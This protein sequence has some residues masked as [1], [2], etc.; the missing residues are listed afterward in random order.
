MVDCGQLRG[1]RAPDRFDRQRQLE[2]EQAAGARFALHLDGAAQRR[3]ESS[4]DRQAEPDAFVAPACGLELHVGLEDHLQLVAAKTDPG[5]FDL[6][7]DSRRRAGQ[8]NA[9][10]PQPQLAGIGELDGVAHQVEQHLAQA[11]AVDLGDRRQPGID[12]AAERQR[13]FGRLDA[14]DVAQALQQVVQMNVG[15]ARLQRAGLEPR[16]VDEVVDEQ[17]HVLPATLDRAERNALLIAQPDVHLKN[18]RVAEDRIQRSPQLVAHRGEELGLGARRELGLTLG[19]AQRL[20]GFLAQRD[21]VVDAGN[22]T[23]VVS[24]HASALDLV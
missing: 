24:I 10:C 7:A 9:A 15:G 21:V 2:R 19:I 18:L 8:R 5:V 6:E 20:L 14:D 13:F 23:L 11:P 3:D 22:G 17:Q 1:R 12:L 4:A 16:D